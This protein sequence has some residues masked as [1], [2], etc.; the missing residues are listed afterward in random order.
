MVKGGSDVEDKLKEHR[1]RVAKVI[2]KAWSDPPFKEKFLANPKA[3]LEENG[4][5]VPPGADVKV[6]EQ[7]EKLIYIVLPFRP[8]DEEGGKWM[9]EDDA[10]DPPCV[11]CV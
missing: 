4:I 8:A 5:T 7:T 6:V 1:K 9:T 10:Y 3:V 2:A 11:R